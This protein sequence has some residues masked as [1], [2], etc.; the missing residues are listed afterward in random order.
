MVSGHSNLDETQVKLVFG[1]KGDDG[2]GDRR[3]QMA[4]G[5]RYWTGIGVNEDCPTAL[6]WYESAADKGWR[7]GS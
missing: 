6:H 2:K 3:A 7:Q 4:L 1:G 5:Y